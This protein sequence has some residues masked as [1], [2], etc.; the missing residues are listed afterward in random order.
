MDRIGAR[1]RA[2]RRN[3]RLTI[4]QAAGRA[5]LNP[6]TVVRAEHGHNPTLLTIVRLLR[7]YDELAELDR[8]LVQPEVSPMAVIRKARARG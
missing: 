3:R 1:L 6:S 4:A 5:N 2:I 7:V 8:F